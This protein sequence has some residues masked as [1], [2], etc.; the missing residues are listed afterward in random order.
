MNQ[1]L[2]FKIKLKFKPKRYQ[3]FG[4]MSRVEFELELDFEI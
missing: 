3:M 4:V 2:N 1:E